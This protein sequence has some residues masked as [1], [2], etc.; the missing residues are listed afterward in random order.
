MTHFTTASVAA[1]ASLKRGR[2]RRTQVLIAALCL[3]SIDAPTTTMTVTY[4]ARAHA[5]LSAPVAGHGGRASRA[6]GGDSAQM[7]S[8]MARASPKSGRNRQNHL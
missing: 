4:S 3:T 8:P 1:P 6:A 5:K 2:R 7:C